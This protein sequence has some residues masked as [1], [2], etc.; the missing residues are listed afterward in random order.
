[1][2]R[3]KGTFGKSSIKRKG[4]T[5]ASQLGNAPLRANGGDDDASSILYGA[6]T[7]RQQN[8]IPAIQGRGLAVRAQRS[9]YISIGSTLQ[10]IKKPHQAL[11]YVGYD[12]DTNETVVWEEHKIGRGRKQTT[13]EKVIYAG[14]E[15]DQAVEEAN[16][17]WT[18]MMENGTAYEGD[19]TELFWMMWKDNH[20]MQSCNRAVSSIIEEPFTAGETGA[21]VEAAEQ[22]WQR[23]EILLEED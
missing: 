3:G 4:G 15:L 16:E 23:G 18:E 17:R 7:P 11:I 1:M 13:E 5:S 9:P 14:Y 22:S 20:F 19:N 2:G 21:A 8:P 6:G 12:I 10:R